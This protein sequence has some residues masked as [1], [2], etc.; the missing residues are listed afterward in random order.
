MA[1]IDVYKD[2]GRQLQGIADILAKAK[3]I[4]VFTGAGVST[5]CDIPVSFPS[6][7]FLI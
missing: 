5:S 6:A 7:A 1:I 4:V 2:S 3:K